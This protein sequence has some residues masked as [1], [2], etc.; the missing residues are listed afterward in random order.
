MPSIDC[1]P[2]VASTS[3]ASGVPSVYDV[4]TVAGFP[5]FAGI[6][7]ILCF[8]AVVFIRAV[9][10]IPAVHSVFA[11]ASFLA[12]PGVSMLLL[13]VSL[14]TVL[15]NDTYIGY[16]TI[17]LRLSECNFFRVSDYW[18]IEYQIGEF[19]KLSDYQISD[20]GP[21]LSDYWISDSQKTSGCPPLTI[22]L[23][24]LDFE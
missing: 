15:Y 19:E 1:V 6:P 2:A 3:A 21:S 4:F 7:G 5:A 9:A 18:N 10:G 22:R 16:W 11:V 14:Y 24:T 8:S 13:L 20:Q 12:I 23:A 17:I